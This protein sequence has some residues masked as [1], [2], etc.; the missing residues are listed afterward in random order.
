MWTLRSCRHNFGSVPFI[1][2]AEMS[3]FFVRN[4]FLNRVVLKEEVLDRAVLSVPN[5]KYLRFCEKYL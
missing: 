5:V 3:Q 2:F 4:P 1:S